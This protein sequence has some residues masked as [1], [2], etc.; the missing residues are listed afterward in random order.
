MSH[1][2]SFAAIVPGENGTVHLRVW[3]RRWSEKNEDPDVKHASGRS[4]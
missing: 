2:Y 4:P 3:L 1:G